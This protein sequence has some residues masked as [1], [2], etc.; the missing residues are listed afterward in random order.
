M[1]KGK[2]ILLSLLTGFLL[3]ISF[4]PMPFSL[5]AFIA[6]VPLFSVLEKKPKRPYLLI[7]FSFSLYHLI[8]NWWLSSW[9]SDTDP[10]LI[11][12]GIAVW[13]VHPLFFILPSII[14]KIIRKKLSFEFSIMIFPFI[15]TVFEWFRTFGDLAYPWLT[16][17][18]TQ[19]YNLYWLQFIDLTG[20]FGASFF[21]VLFNSIFLII[22]K[23]IQSNKLLPNPVGFLKIKNL[24]LLL[25]SLIA[26]IIIPY[27]Y[28][29]VK[30]NEYNFEK[31]KDS[32]KFARIGVVQ[33]N[34]N[35]WRKWEI[36]TLEQIFLH[37]NLQD[38]LINT[39]GKLDLVIWP[40]TAI[41]FH[42]IEL[43]SEYNFNFLIED[44]VE[45]QTSLLTGFADIVFLKP[46]EK[47]SAT[48]KK[49]FGDETRYYN[50]YNSVLVLNY[51]EDKTKNP[52]IYHKMKLTP[53]GERVP[54]VEHL[55]FALKWLEWGVGISSWSI[56]TEQKNLI[57][58]NPEQN[59]KIAPIICIE[60]VYPEFVSNFSKLGAD[61]LCVITNDGWYDYTF[62]PEQ[63]YQ[64][65]VARA[66]ENR[67]FLVRCA[68]TGISGV[69][70][71]TGFSLIKAPQ[72]SRMAFASE[73]PIIKGST[74][75]AQYGDWLPLSSLFIL[76]G[77]I[78]LVII[79][80]FVKK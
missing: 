53:F 34:I 21:I 78:I 12:S 60:S 25:L 30:V 16:I 32:S 22:L 10:Y 7:Y 17:G 31:I 72:Y 65:A 11:V 48:S 59:F 77:V 5:L 79:K 75:Y 47:I 2:N 50:S 58:E 61:I 74:F 39:V 70:Q 20:I 57:I 29:F 55:K 37:K 64:I 24:K 62:G 73:V 33:G 36:S 14:Y 42:S 38:S 69:I 15:W 35:P 71:P 80:S 52:Q 27:I 40:E 26:I 18:Y 41:T 28:G 46:G 54:Y 23:K 45:K 76:I 51:F 63:H 66:I 13:L 43:N 6:F 67:K 49:F 8:S 3:G 19:V 44:L 68:N 9:Q 56:G 4:P 1:K